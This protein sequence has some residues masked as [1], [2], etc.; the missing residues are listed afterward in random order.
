M[1]TFTMIT[2]TAAAAF[3]LV[4][5][6]PAHA[7]T[8]AQLIDQ[9]SN[10]TALSKED[11]ERVLDGFIDE[12]QSSVAEG[13]RVVLQNFGAFGLIHRIVASDGV[14]SAGELDF[15][16]GAAFV[17]SDDAQRDAYKM[18]VESSE[19]LGDGS[20]RVMGPGRGAIG[21]GD[22]VTLLPGNPS[23]LAPGRAHAVVPL[24]LL[25]TVRPFEIGDVNDDGEVNAL[26]VQ[27]VINAALGIEV[28]LDKS[29]PLDTGRGGPV[30]TR[31]LEA[32]VA[33]VIVLNEAGER[34]LV[35]EAEGQTIGLLL[36]GIR[37]QDIKRGM[38]IA[39]PATAA[40]PGIPA[41]KQAM[42]FD[43]QGEPKGGL[44]SDGE[45]VQAIS[46]KIGMDLNAVIAAYNALLNIVVDEVNADGKVQIIGFGDF[47]SKTRVS[48]S[49]IDPCAGDPEA[50]AGGRIEISAPFVPWQVTLEAAGV[51]RRALARLVEMATRLAQHE[52]RTSPD[53]QTGKEVKINASRQVILEIPGDGSV[54]D[55]S[56]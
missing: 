56:V 47:V 35:D 29:P 18:R 33:G 9:I 20:V 17:D 11:A 30:D 38:V 42:W 14:E 51:E 39:K 36:L 13:D 2:A 44:R 50:C 46:D 8:K 31:M 43:A 45:L 41:E 27:I 12:I 16:A 7:M 24:D 25:E 37:P 34:E 22:I 40:E 52:I 19:R 28:E 21:T 10:K 23:V 49:I 48:V 15:L 32:E 5:M 26:D 1:R 54:A 6:M 4:A 53:P 3:L 55:G